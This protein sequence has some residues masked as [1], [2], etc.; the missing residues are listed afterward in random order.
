MI[1]D[2]VAF[3]RD[4]C[5][6]HGIRVGHISRVGN[7]V[8]G[9]VDGAR[10]GYAC[11]IDIAGGGPVGT[12]FGRNRAGSGNIARGV[13]CSERGV[14]DRGGVKG[15][16][17][18]HASRVCNVAVCGDFLRVEGSAVR[19][20][21]IGS[22][23]FIGHVHFTGGIGYI[24]RGDN[25]VGV[26]ANGSVGIRDIFA[27]D[28]ARRV[29]HAFIDHVVGGGNIGGSGNRTGVGYACAGHRAVGV[30]SGAGVIGN[31][32]DNGDGSIGVQNGGVGQVLT[33]NAACGHNSEVVFDIACCVDIGGVEQGA[34]IDD[35]VTGRYSAGGH[36][37]GAGTV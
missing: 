35:I 16:G 34:V 12:C 13:H 14:I 28:I 32:V 17:N 30:P 5:G 29:D 15:S 20:G 8:G 3:R 22:G 26:H 1:I 19:V 2:D 24:G 10:V 21:D 18:G 25:I 6:G 37:C 7:D 27:G 31:R 23:D 33:G 9:T 11:A 36:E 4:I